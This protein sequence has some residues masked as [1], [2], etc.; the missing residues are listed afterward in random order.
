[1]N[2]YTIRKVNFINIPA[3]LSVSNILYDCGKDM[4]IKYNLHHWDNGKTKSFLVAVYTSLRSNTFLV[5]DNNRNCVATFQTKKIEDVLHFSKLATKPNYAG[6]GIGSFCMSEIEKKA[7]E[8]LCK[9]VSM[10]VY[11]KS[12]HAIDFYLHK[13]YEKCGE[14]KTLK[15]TEIKMQK[16]IG[17][18][19]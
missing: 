17:T 9:K 10:E 14:V 6:K 2:N 3:M 5:E 15:Y 8:S 1:M 19:K 18:E 11:D 7:V 4:A 13:G 12:Q 16:G